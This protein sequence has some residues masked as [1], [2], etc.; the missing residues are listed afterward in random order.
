[1]KKEKN[2]PGPRSRRL[3]R[4]QRDGPVPSSHPLLS[5]CL[6]SHLPDTPR[7]VQLSSR[8]SFPLPTR[9]NCPDPKLGFSLHRPRKWVLETEA[10]IWASA[11]VPDP[12]PLAKMRQVCRLGRAWFLAGFMEPA[13][14][15][16]SADPEPEWDLTAAGALCL[17]NPGNRHTAPD[18][19]KTG[20]RS[21][22]LPRCSQNPPG[23]CPSVWIL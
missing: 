3:L 7:R 5:R 8:Q 22:F 14:Q 16:G 2:F 4:S 19:K 17:V 21:A 12:R 6:R 20:Q 1:M 13:A 23:F 10:R 15:A 18:M 11:S 9:S